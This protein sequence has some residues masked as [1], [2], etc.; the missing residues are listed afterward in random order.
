[1]EKLKERSQ[2]E[3]W[4]NLNIAREHREHS[5]FITTRTKARYRNWSPKLSYLNSSGNPSISTATGQF[6]VFLLFP[7]S[8][9]RMRKISF[10][11]FA[12]SA[13]CNFLLLQ[14]ERHQPY[15]T[16]NI[17]PRPTIRSP[18][19]PYQV[20]TFNISPQHTRQ[21]FRSRQDEIF[22]PLNFTLFGHFKAWKSTETFPTL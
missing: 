10:A 9:V 3:S 1:M 17:K 15:V 16:H 7:I 20:P 6:F 12:L 5:S 11:P 8:C 21:R 13:T 2:D 19:L 18:K 14:L 4:E 22:K